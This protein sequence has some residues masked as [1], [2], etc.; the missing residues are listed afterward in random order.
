MPASSTVSAG[1]RAFLAGLALMVLWS[2][3]V[4][5]RRLVVRTVR[6]S[7]TGWPAEASPLTVVA[8]SDFHTGSPGMD[9]DKLRVVVD[10]VN[11]I[12]PDL[13]VLLGDFVMHGV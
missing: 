7:L 2:V 3:G 5:P 8:L 4:E 10:R 6:L 9:L 11:R 13:V 1:R 12:H